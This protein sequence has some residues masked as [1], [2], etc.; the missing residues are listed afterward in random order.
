MGVAPADLVGTEETSPERA[1]PSQVAADIQAVFTQAAFITPLMLV[2][3]L[4]SAAT[5]LPLVHT[6]T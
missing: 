6:G 2:M 3:P 1:L 4:L 5:S